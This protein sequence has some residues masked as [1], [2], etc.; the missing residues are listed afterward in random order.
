MASIII[1]MINAWELYSICCIEFH[2]V[3]ENK[4][5]AF[6]QSLNKAYMNKTK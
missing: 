3:Y 5:G 6:S 1:I 4:K 2:V